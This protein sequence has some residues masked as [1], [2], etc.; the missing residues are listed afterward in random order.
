[1][2]KAIFAC[3]AFGGIGNRG[4]LPWPQNS[5]DLNWFKRN[6]H[7]QI[8]VMGKGT[9]DDPQ[10]PKPLPDR[11][12]VVITHKYIAMPGVVCY[13][14]DWQER[15]ISL[16][17]KENKDV[18][19]I[20]GKSLLDQGRDIIEQVYITRMKGKYYTDVSINLQKYLLG[21]RMI[22]CSPGDDSCTFEVWKRWW[23]I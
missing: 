7:D 3:D 19:I 12:N 15:V 10:M 21:W 23:N 14:K 16:G 5:T 6:T 11:I 2:I 1:M 18:W 22:S 9:W 17:Q 13:S 20:G 8:V 4:T